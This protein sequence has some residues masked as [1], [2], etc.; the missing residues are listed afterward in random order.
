[1]IRAEI[2]QA[3]VQGIRSRR[4]REA[5]AR[6]VFGA[7]RRVTA[8]VPARTWRRASAG[9]R[10]PA[11]LDDALAHVLRLDLGELVGGVG[12]HHV[13]V[14]AAPDLVD[15]A[16][17]GADLVLAAGAARD[18]EQERARD[19]VEVAAQEIGVGAAV[20]DVVIGA[21]VDRVGASAAERNVVA[22]A[23]VDRV[24]AARAVERV[25]AVAAEQ[26]VGTGVAGQRVRAAASLDGLN[27]RAEIVVAR[28][29]RR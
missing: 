27:V 26:R 24:G 11:G 25:G 2:V 22:G 20:D 4:P 7:P 15:R 17:L 1:M 14:E 21:A 18:A 3:R 13:G 8:S 9:A 6:P 16:V 12:L 29:C 10:A 19:V 28:R 5:S 23:A